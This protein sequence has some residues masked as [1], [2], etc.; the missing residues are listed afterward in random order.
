ML[1]VGVMVG[2]A[3]AVTVGVAV[4]VMVMFVHTPPIQAA[5]S[6]IAPSGQVPPDA[7]LAQSSP[8]I[9]HW[10]HWSGRNVGRA[11]GVIVAQPPGVAIALAMQVPSHGPPF[12]SKPSGYGAPHRQHAPGPHVGIGVGVGVRVAQTAGVPGVW[13]IAI[14]PGAQI[15]SQKF[16][17]LK[18]SG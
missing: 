12:G 16:V 1:G 5:G 9:E 13:V 2:V 8:L 6:M 3:V 18:A 7:P 4:G 15:P 17:V 11:V 10:Q 14:A